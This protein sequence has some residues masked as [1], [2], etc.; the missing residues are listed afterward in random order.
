MPE[1]SHPTYGCKNRRLRP[2]VVHCQV[3]NNYVGDHWAAQRN[4]QEN[5]P[6]NTIVQMFEQARRVSMGL[7]SQASFKRGSK[8]HLNDFYHVSHATAEDFHIEPEFLRPLLKSPSDTPTIRIHPKDL[9]LW[10][11]TGPMKWLRENTILVA[12]QIRQDLGT[13]AWMVRDVLEEMRFT[14]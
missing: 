4:R 10:V 11:S 1:Q 13:G 12:G 14:R 8:T 9:P 5:V 3:V 2:A 7:S 6:P